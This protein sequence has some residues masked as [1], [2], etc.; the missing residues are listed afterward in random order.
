MRAKIELAANF[1]QVAPTEP[2]AR[3]RVRRSGSRR[4]GVSFTWRTE[5]G[6]AVAGKDFVSVN[7][8]EGH[9][10]PGQSEVVLYV[11]IFSYSSRRESKNFYVVIGDPGPG[12]VLGGRFIAMITIPA[13]Q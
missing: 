3:V 11:P 5:A 6:T 9:I 4:S 2:F 12:A 7:A 1:V 8:R 10:A 13:A